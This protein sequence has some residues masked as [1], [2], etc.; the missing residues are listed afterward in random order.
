MLVFYTICSVISRKHEVQILALCIMPD[1]FHIGALADSRFSVRPFV[2]EVQA[3]YT[4]SFNKFYGRV[5]RLFSKG[6]GSSVKRGL[7]DIISTLNY[8]NNNPGV[9]NLTDRA[10]HTLWNFLAYHDTDRFLSNGGHSNTRSY[11]R[12]V[13]EVK[14]YRRDD[15]PLNHN[16][17]YRIMK[18]LDN[19]DK[20]RLADFIICQYAFINYNRAAN[21][22][23]SWK[24]M[25]TA[26]NSN[27]G[28]D[29]LVKEVIET[30]DYKPYVVLSNALR[31]LHFDSRE[32][33]ARTPE[34]R[35]SLAYDLSAL[36]PT[37]SWRHIEK[38]LHLPKGVLSGYRERV[39]VKAHFR[40]LPD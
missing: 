33:F 34:D 23:G 3:Y 22:Y 40:S 8:I 9:G 32:I 17:L 5:G 35:I 37:A 15:K 21:F 10:E 18:P 25:L 14:V 20:A 24:D 31:M 38:F 27:T 7:K 12:A 6:F 28:N 29:H 19:D 36:V 13:E 1:H 26:A 16:L 39:R 11:R 4:K 2:S 30:R